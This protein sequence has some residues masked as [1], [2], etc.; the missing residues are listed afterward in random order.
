MNEDRE[1]HGKKPLKE[2]EP[3][4]PPSSSSGGS[5]LTEVKTMKGSTKWL[6]P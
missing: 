4:K 5:D 6:V 2:K 3:K 1:T